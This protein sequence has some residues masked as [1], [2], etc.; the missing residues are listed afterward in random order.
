[1][2]N[3]TVQELKI[4]TIKIDPGQPRKTF[5]GDS[6]KELADSISKV[7]L[8]QPITVRPSGKN[9]I[10]VMGER[11]YRACKL[12]KQETIRCLVRELDKDTILEIQIIENLQR[13][14]VEPI[15]EA[16]AIAMLRSRYTPEEI[17]V[18]IGRTK[19]F[20]YGRI[21]LS[22]LID[23]FK[24][25]V[26][27]KEMTISLAIAVASLPVEEQ[28]LILEGM[29]G[30][31][32]ERYVQNSINRQTF[33]LENAPFALDND[34]LVPKV[35]ACTLCPFNSANQGS[36]FG[37]GKQ[38]CTKSSCYATKKTKSLLNLIGETK[39][40]GRLLIPKFYGHNMDMD[41]NRL[42][43]SILKE[44][45]FTVHLMDDMEILTEPVEPTAELIRKKTYWKEFTDEEMKEE[46]EKAMD[47]YN[48]ELETF[49][50]A[51]DHGYAIGTLVDPKTY[52]W[53]EVLMKEE[54]EAV[55][56]T[57]SLPIDKKKMDDCT[58]TEKIQ[59]MN[60]R[61]IRKKQ[62]ENN[63]LFEEV[64]GMVRESKYIDTKKTLSADEMVAFCFNLYENHIGWHDQ[65]EYFKG[66]LGDTS[67][68][69]RVEAVEEFKK[70]FKKETFHRLIRFVLMKQVHFGE[71]NHVNDHVNISFY[72]AV[73]GYLK[74]DIETTE[75]V[76]GEKRAQREKRLKERIEALEKENDLLKSA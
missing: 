75:A 28:Q 8:L 21:K 16:E 31:F 18:S 42:I 17:A 59:K 14:D 20:V 29:G 5:S 33:D 71:R 15:E 32:K 11:R 55:H 63:K 27:N 6:L 73:K 51:S 4:N 70:N 35:G 72:T 12:L 1:M 36:L 30:E 46:L 10:I 19:K 37:D 2:E 43:L 45:G 60:D 9:L 3:Q 64:A 24:P 7:G 44:N 66:F 62:I 68:K 57:R 53:E 22:Q 74:K 41:D 23:G 13:K 34:K 50:N 38:I 25:V 56:D 54:E 49:K 52:L 65:R 76:Y 47:S 69:S 26:K 67:R 58:P 39:K 48:E 61:E 40:D